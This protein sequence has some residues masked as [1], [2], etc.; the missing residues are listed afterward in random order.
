MT[1]TQNLKR[2]AVS[3]T[4]APPPAGSYSQAVIAG[5]LVHISGQTPRTPEGDRRGG[6]PFADQVRLTLD[7]VESIAA[8]AGTRLAAAAMVTVYLR[9]PAAQAAAFD[10]IYRQHLLAEVAPPARAVVQSD[11]PHGHIE[12]TA[13]IPVPSAEGHSHGGL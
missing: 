4:T 3:T 7:N 1:E 6:A 8:E 5:G 13:V 12:V 9:D 2:A 11:L 10:E